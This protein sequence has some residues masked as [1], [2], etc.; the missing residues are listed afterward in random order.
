MCRVNKV[1]LYVDD[2]ICPQLTQN[3]RIGF[4]YSVMCLTMY[5]LLLW[6]SVREASSMRRHVERDVAVP[7]YS[8]AVFML[9][10]VSAS[11]SFCSVSS[12]NL[13]PNGELFDRYLSMR[14]C[15]TV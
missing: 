9:Y 14:V 11:E 2:C 8:R 1:F 3:D 7:L 4:H 13:S 12:T 5:P 15:V 6:L 10:D